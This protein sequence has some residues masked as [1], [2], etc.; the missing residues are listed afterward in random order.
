[1][2]R[3]PSQWPTLGRNAAVRPRIV[4]NRPTNV[5]NWARAT[6]IVLDSTEQNVYALCAFGLFLKFGGL[7]EG[8]VWTWL[9]RPC[10]AG[11]LTNR[12]VQIL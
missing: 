8:V 1:M 7:G 3:L 9:G 12:N 6:R 4:H 5:R 11:R 10:F 2:G